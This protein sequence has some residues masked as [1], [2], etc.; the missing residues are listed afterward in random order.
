MLYQ[1][2][3]LYKDTKRVD[4]VL[5]LISRLEPRYAKGHK[6]TTFIGSD[7]TGSIPIPFWNDDGNTVQVGDFLEIQNGYISEFR[8]QVQLNVG[9][10]GNFRK[11]D[12][13]EGFE[14]NDKTP[15]PASKPDTATEDDPM[16]L[17]EFYYKKKSKAPLRLFVKERVQERTVHTKHD[18]Q[19]HQVNTFLVGDASG[20]ML[21]NAWDDHIAAIKVGATLQITNLY[22]RT[23]QKRQY[24]NLARTSRVSPCNAVTKINSKNN[25][26]ELAVSSEDG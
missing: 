21:L 9:K 13:P 18:G 10:F 4:I 11:I 17:E 14:V 19:E 7:A 15:P 8:E 16:A 23:F 3:D 1:V 2:K 20:C 26:S 22:I 5:K 24:L 6:I 12:S 25:L